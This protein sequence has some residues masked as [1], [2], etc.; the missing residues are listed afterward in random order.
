[1]ETQLEHKYLDEDHLIEESLE[2]TKGST[3][4]AE[5]IEKQLDEQNTRQIH[6]D[7]TT[8]TPLAEYSESSQSYVLPL[9]AKH[10]QRKEHL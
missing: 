4:K 9:V 6:V 10:I 1:M 5:N 7:P 3:S 8:V 2:I